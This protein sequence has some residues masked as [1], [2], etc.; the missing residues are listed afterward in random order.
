MHYLY[1]ITNQINGKIYIGQSNNNRRW[2]QHKYFAKHP[3]QTGQHIHRAMAKY[4]VDNFVFE[5]IATCRTQEDANEVESFLIIQYDSRNKEYGYNSRI[6]GIAGVRGTVSEETKKKQS[7]GMKKAYERN[8]N[9]NLGTK[10]TEEQRAKMSAAQQSLDRTNMYP[11][12]VRQRM[13]EAHIGKVIPEEQREKMSASIQ[14][15]WDERNT[16]RFATEEIRCFAPDCKISGK[17]KY[18][19]IDGVRYCN[20]HGLRMLRHGSLEKLPTFKYTEDNPMPEE[21]R[22]KCGIANVGRIAHNRIIFTEEQITS[23]LQ[24]L[25]SN[26]KIAKDFNVTEK[27]IK[28][29][30]NEKY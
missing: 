29:I 25:R 26:K 6:G 15:W 18:K 17:A 21:I 22:R 24:D 13:S 10:R 14:E 19:I 28:R 7:E 4:G 27:V 1:R 11:E 3:E 23:I 16:E 30:K 5:K 12:E 9:W 20:M 2:S 8:G